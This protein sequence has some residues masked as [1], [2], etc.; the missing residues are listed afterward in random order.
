MLYPR[1]RHGIQDPRLS[2]HMRTL[3]WNAIKTKL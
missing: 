2:Q 3:M 1:Q